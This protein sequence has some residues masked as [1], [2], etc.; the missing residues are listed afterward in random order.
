MPSSVLE[1][2]PQPG[3]VCEACRTALT[4]CELT[5]EPDPDLPYRLCAACLERLESFTLRPLE[6]FN[7]AVLHS[8]S[9]Y[10]LHDDFYDEDGTSLALLHDE[11]TYPS[12]RAEMESLP[13]PT[14]D[15]VRDDLERLVDY[16][17]TRWRLREDVIAALR[18]HPP[19]VLLAVLQRRTNATKNWA[20]ESIAL[21]VCAE[22]VGPP[23]TKWV[24]ERWAGPHARELLRPLAQASAACLPQEE[25]LFRVM[26]AVDQRR[27]AYF[28]QTAGVLAYFRSSRVLDWIENELSDPKSVVADSWGRLAAASQLSWERVERWLNGGRPLSLVA[29]DGMLDCIPPEHPLRRRQI[30][31]EL[32]NPPLKE[33]GFAALDRYASMDSVPRVLRAVARIKEHWDELVAR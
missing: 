7:L 10:H 33:L 2:D 14:L 19:D 25:G 26:D 27:D 3:K 8:S 16:A 1:I 9:R 28:H 12:G 15:E 17:F 4:T 31:P 20:I 21:D 24:R 13:A 18:S 29:L 5:D 30:Q 6:Y 32:L 11:T 23:A 22:A